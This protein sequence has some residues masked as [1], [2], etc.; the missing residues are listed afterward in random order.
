ML[1]SHFS[2]VQLLETPWTIAFQAPFSM[3][4]PGKNSEAGCHF[5]LQGIFGT[6]GP[7]RTPVSPAFQADSLLL[8]HHGSPCS[9]ESHLKK[10]SVEAYL[11]KSPKEYD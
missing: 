4:F 6:Q 2:R 8:S 11:W 1:L 10:E 3:G 9:E 5:L 7:N